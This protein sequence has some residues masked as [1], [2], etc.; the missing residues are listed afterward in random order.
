LRGSVGRAE[1]NDGGGCKKAKTAPRLFKKK[2]RRDAKRN[3]N[4]L[5]NT[6]FEIICAAI[7]VN[8][9]AVVTAITAGVL[10]TSTV[11]NLK[12]TRE[13]EKKQRKSHLDKVCS[14]EEGDERSVQGD[15]DH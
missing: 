12:Q 13:V 15:K 6:E 14:A 7:V 4:V 8:G 2:K 1:R 11:T 3:G 10:T 5:T 9:V